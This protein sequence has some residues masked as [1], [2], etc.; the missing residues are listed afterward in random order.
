[1]LSEHRAGRGARVGARRAPYYGPVEA[2][3][4]S[5]QVGT[6][7]P[8]ARRA[9]TSASQGAGP[10]GQRPDVDPTTSAFAVSSAL[11]GARHEFGSQAW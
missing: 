2:L 9:M 4:T 7:D 5:F 8:A 6:H 3:R 1:V 10:G 11:V